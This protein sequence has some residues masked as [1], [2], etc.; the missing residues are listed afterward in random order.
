M[1]DFNLGHTTTKQNIAVS[2]AYRAFLPCAQPVAAGGA[3]DRSGQGN[4][5]SDQGGG[6]TDINMWGNAGHA[7]TIDGTDSGFGIPASVALWDLAAGESLILA[8]TMKMATP[9]ILDGIIGNFKDAVNGAGLR[10]TSSGLTGAKV[11]LKDN[12]NN[13]STSVTINSGLLDDIEHKVIVTV[14]A[15]TKL[16]SAYVDVVSATPVDISDIVGTTAPSTLPFNFGNDGN[17]TEAGKT[18]DGLFRDIH[19]LAL[20]GGDADNPVGLPSNILEIVNLYQS[21]YYIPFSVDE[22]GV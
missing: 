9:A 20:G 10:F 21:R 13:V 15:V 1:T 2:T 5:A 8:L 18:Y 11:G 4:D 6:L 19:L 17:T 3:I 14:D 16:M 7:S 12:S 22:I